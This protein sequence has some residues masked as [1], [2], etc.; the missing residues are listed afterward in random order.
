[1]SFLFFLTNVSRVIVFRYILKQIKEF[2]KFFAL[3]LEA[4]NLYETLFGVKLADLYD[5]K[6]NLYS[7]ILD[8][9]FIYSPYLMK[10][11]HLFRL[12]FRLRTIED[13]RV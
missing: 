7:S 5:N 1:M 13:L 2:R 12:L 8:N 11:S 10:N 6:P 9:G 3:S 4:I